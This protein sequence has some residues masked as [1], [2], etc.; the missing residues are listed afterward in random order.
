M[1]KMEFG[2]EEEEKWIEVQ[3]ERDQWDREEEGN[4]HIG[5]QP[6][7]KD[8]EILLEKWSSLLFLMF[9]EVFFRFN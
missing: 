4:M 1:T 8:E 6:E 2:K 7:D 5:R 9:V 3:K